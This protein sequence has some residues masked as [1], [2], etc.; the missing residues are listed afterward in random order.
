[1]FDFEMCKTLAGHDLTE[2]PSQNPNASSYYCENCGA[3][4]C[5]SPAKELV[6]FHVPRGSFSSGSKCVKAGTAVGNSRTSLRAKLAEL[7]EL[8]EFPQ[9]VENL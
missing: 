4:V 8:N 3:L 9:V 6:F 7:S 2:I 5:L 1:M